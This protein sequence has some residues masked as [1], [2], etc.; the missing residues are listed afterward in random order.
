MGELLPPVR[1]RASLIYSPHPLLL[2]AGRVVR[3]EAPLPGE[4]LACYLV[5]NGVDIT[6]PIVVAVNGDA[7]PRDWLHRVRPKTGT[8]V[9]VRGALAGGDD[10]NPLAFV[11]MIA[12]MVAAPYLGAA[13]ASS[14]MGGSIAATTFIGGTTITGAMIGTSVVTLAGAMIV[15]KIFA[16]P[17]ADLGRG[18][19]SSSAS[20]TYSISGGQN[21]SR[22]YEPLPLTLGTHRVFFDYA[23]KPY[24]VFEGEDQYLYQMFMV[25]MVGPYGELDVSDLRIGDTPISSYDDVTIESSVGSLPTLAPANVDTTAGGAVTVADGAVLRTTSAGTTRIEIDLQASVFRV[26]NSGYTSASLEYRAEYRVAGSSDAW[27]TL[28]YERDPDYYSH[29]WSEGYYASEWQAIS[30]DYGEWVNVW[31]QTGFDADRSPS[32]H[33][34]GVGGWRWMA[35]SAKSAQWDAPDRSLVTWDSA[36]VI[37]SSSATPVRLTYGRDVA[38]GQYEVRLQKITADS[39]EDRLTLDLTWSSL[40]SYQA[41]DGYYEGQQFLAVKIKASGQLNGVLDRFNGLVKQ[42]TAADEFSNNPADLFL[43]FAKGHQSAAGRPLWGGQLATADLDVSAIAAW[44]S[45]CTDKALSCNVQI[46]SQRSVWDVL[47]AI[48]RCGRASPTWASGKL[49]VVW[50]ADSQPVVATFGMGNIVRGSFRVEYLSE[51]AV[52]EIVLNYIDAENDYEVATV[53]APDGVVSPAKTGMLELWGCTNTAMAVKEANLAYAENVYRTRSIS[54]NTDM[55]GLVVTRGDVVAL[56]HDL[57]Q[58]GSSGRLLAGTTTQVT[59]DREIQ[60]DAGGTWIGVTDP[61]GTHTVCRVQHN[62]SPSAVLTLLDALPSAPNDDNPIDWRYVADYLATPGKLVKIVSIKPNGLRSVTITA[63][64][65]YDEYYAAENGSY[66]APTRRE[67]LSDQPVI[68]SLGATEQKVVSG[69]STT[70]KLVITW[71]ESGNVASRR[72]RYS[73]DGGA[74]QVAGFADGSR[75]ELILGDVGTV[76]V[77]VTLYDGA[78]QTSSAAQASL[79]YTLAG[80]AYAPLSLE[81]LSAAGELFQIRLSW[82]FD[83]DVNEVKHVAV[84]GAQVNSRGAA[85]LLTTIAAPTAGWLHTG[86]PPGATWYY[87]ARVVDAKGRESDWFPAGATSGVSA[88]SVSDPA[89]IVAALVGAISEDELTIDLS[90]R[91]NKIDAPTTGALA[92]ITALQGQVDAIQSDVADLSGTP[93]YDNATT[94]AADDLVKYSGGL[95]RA[96]STTTGN[97]PTNATYWQKIGDYASIGDAVAGLAVDVD[98][99]DTRVG[100]AEGAISSEV[101]ARQTLATQV[102]GSYTGSD[103]AALSSGLL[104]SE[105]QARS[106]ADASE[107]TA[108]QG[109]AA[110]LTGFSD[111]TGK[112]LANLTSGIVYE[113][114]TARASADGALASRTDTLET[115]VGGHTTTLSIHGTSINGIQAKYTVKIDNNGYMSGYGLISTANNGTPTSAFTV[116]ADQFKVVVPGKTAQVPFVVGTVNGASAVGINGALAVDGS[117]TAT[118]I[119]TRGLTIKDASGNV[120]LSSGVP[121]NFSYLEG[122]PSATDLLNANQ[123]WSQVSGASDLGNLVPDVNFADTAWGTLSGDWAK[124]SPVTI[125]VPTAIRWITTSK[126]AASGTNFLGEKATPSQLRFPVNPGER[127]YYSAR[128]ATQSTATGT[129]DM[130][131]LFYNSAGSLVSGTEWSDRLQ[132]TVPSASEQSKSG[133]TIVPTG[134]THAAFRV[135]RGSVANAGTATGWC[136]VG[137]IRVSRTQDGATVGADWSSNVSNIPYDTVYNND[138][139]VALGFNPTFSDWPTGDARPTGWAAWNTGPTKETT[140]KRVGEFS[141]KFTPNGTADYGMSRTVTWD[142][143][144]LPAGTF[145]SGTVDIYL[146]SYTGP[147]KPGIRIE[148]FSSAGMASSY[149]THVPVPSTATG[150][151]QRVPFT[152]RV[153]SGVRIYGMRIHVFASYGYDAVNYGS[154]TGTVYYDNLR[155]ALF[156]SS[157]DNK[158][159]SIGSDGSLTG[160][161]GGQVTITGLGYSGALNATYGADI[162]STLRRAGLPVAEADLLASWNKISS[163]NAATFFNSSGLPGTYIKDLQVSKLVAGA[164]GVSQWIS[165]VGYVAGSS[166]WAINANGSAEFR[167]IVARGDIEATTIKAG[168]ANIIDTLMLQGEAVVVPRQADGGVA[169]SGYG[170]WTTFLTAAP[171][172]VNGGSIVVIV[173]YSSP[174]E[175]SQP[176]MR[177]TRNGSNAGLLFSGTSYNQ[178]YPYREVRAF[179]FDAAT[180]GNSSQTFAVQY[181]QHAD[182]FNTAAAKLVVIGAKR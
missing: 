138:D 13:L 22:P 155:F 126:T 180:V 88:S 97:L 62:A 170:T 143:A 92:Q 101:T 99:L 14:A 66:T 145:V 93:D 116:L 141:A 122:S 35:Y 139:S 76:L 32:A 5:R 135:R 125:G 90:T 3:S 79:S 27:Q 43:F 87:W 130:T 117:I 41:D 173:E 148:L 1:E 181:Y 34:D 151:W 38:S 111:P 33:T 98:D 53:R 63:V 10:S 132:F 81:S 2:E 160:A 147:G 47:S 114:K 40:K 52:D 104:W 107:V 137:Q 102:R 8:L 105:R 157:V 100:V 89:D 129:W 154:W 42:P 39:T 21:Q 165:S 65:E 179:V 16:A 94:Y 150:V 77:E 12:L 9:T 176:S 112:T 136:E 48:A 134:A 59:L 28:V 158:T 70:T 113:E 30:G 161:G 18:L 29:Y 36:P 6:R 172:N 64:D 31:K 163:G 152:A 159:V 182:H 82:G 86:L 72:V 4:T 55:E 83:G 115:T 167:N 11:A 78:G 153:P 19:S 120:I 67:W 171:V 174:A 91:I 95:Y 96:L 24:A 49:G 46:D 162:G 25:G 164:L 51:S 124:W 26:G 178:G 119:D 128:S 118:K 71:A 131:L 156:D 123:Q 73:I 142:A 17:K 45:F 80:V 85:T 57:T 149:F 84:Y 61:E 177:L 15:N 133:S 106:T 175:D 37:T 74:L 103:I 166:G 127:L 50:D 68:R 146:G 108:R 121:L 7:I 58:W 169:C 144:P 23:G 109:L 140:I 75:Y 44:R 20:P 110:T 56:S 69:G 168:S 54:W 60:T